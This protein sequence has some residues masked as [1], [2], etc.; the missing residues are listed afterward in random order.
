MCQK[1]YIFVI[2]LCFFHYN[3]PT[4][5]NIYFNFLHHGIYMLLLCRNMRIGIIIIKDHHIG[6][7]LY[8]GAVEFQDGRQSSRIEEMK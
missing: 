8:L 1:F 6:M 5:K 7:L 2:F 3:F 4:K